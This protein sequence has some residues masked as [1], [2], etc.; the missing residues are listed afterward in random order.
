MCIRD[1]RYF[2]LGAAPDT[3]EQAAAYA[4][5]RFPGWTEA[6][7]HHGFISGV[8]NQEVVERINASQ[9]NMLLV[10]MGNPIQ[11]RWIE[12]HQSK[13]R[14]PLAIGVG[15][16]F[17][18]WVNKPRRAP[19]WVRKMG[20]EWVHKLILQPHKWRRYLLGNPQFIVRMTRAMQRDVAAMNGDLSGK[21]SIR[22][23][24]PPISLFTQQS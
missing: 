21:Q 8:Q 9:S 12:R 2:L 16:L 5:K 11:E 6:G 4:K 3:V 7:Y 18:H 17:D 20:C 10:G 1:S 15:G 13:L 23:Q 14:V 24:A 19:L 22:L